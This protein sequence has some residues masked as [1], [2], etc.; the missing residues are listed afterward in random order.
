MIYGFRDLMGRMNKIEELEHGHEIY[1]TSML[2]CS[3]LYSWRTG[4]LRFFLA[5]SRRR[6][7]IKG[8]WKRTRG[9]VGH[10]RKILDQ[11]G[12]DDVE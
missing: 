7:R 12:T 3:R 5:S 8:A 2:H 6:S 11:W 4:M 9:L 1:H 10:D